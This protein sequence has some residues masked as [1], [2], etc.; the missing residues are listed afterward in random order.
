M[1]LTRF[2]RLVLV[3]VFGTIFAGC[4]SLR[5]ERYVRT[6]SSDWTTCG[7]TIE[8][9][10]STS[11]S[12]EPPLELKWEYN[13]SAGFG[14][15]SPLV[16]DSTVFIGTLQGELHAVRIRDG[17]P[18]GYKAFKSAI[19]GAPVLQG[20]IVYVTSALDEPT[21]IAY[22]IALAKEV[23]ARDVGP[24]ETSPLLVGKKLIVATLSGAVVCVDES[25]GE[26]I[27]RY[28]SKKQIH[29]SP[30]SD[31][32]LVVFG[33]D[34][35]SITGLH[36][37]DGTLAWT[38]QT[39]SSVF[40]PPAI[41]GRTAF[42]GSTD[43]NFYAVGLEDGV[44]RW[45]RNLESKVYGGAAVASGSV[46]VGTVNGTLYALDTKDG[47]TR[48]FFRAESVI[49]SAPLAA[50]NTLYV[51][52]LDTF[53]YALDA[54]TGQLLWQYR[55]KGR[56]KTNLAAW[57]NYLIVASEDETLYAFQPKNPG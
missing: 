40:A 28:E 16:A 12:I 57:R 29:S 34:D 43:E 39:E 13:A 24:I 6:E 41:E 3:S 37:H 52:S 18:V 46:F 53:L 30:A 5:L 4:T 56:I 9:S 1:N 45:K 21:L 17:E 20:N 10:N 35:G 31:G 11:T 42:I 47:A 54:R 15:G 38:V 51:G 55:T 22:N 25:Q 50:G 14:T 8:R 32:S 49:D 44:V 2:N 48:W 33:G 23:W 36:L 7:G 26:E 27:W 19:V